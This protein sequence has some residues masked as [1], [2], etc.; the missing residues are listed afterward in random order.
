MYELPIGKGHQFLNS[1][2]A[3]HGLG[4]WKV[5]GVLTLM[6]GS[7]VNFS[8]SAAGLSAPGN[9]QSP[10][11][12]API[13]VLHG[14]NVGNPWFSTGSFAA[15]ATGVFGNVGRNNFSGPGFFNLDFSLFKIFK[16]SERMGLELRAES[17][18]VTNTPQFNNP[19]TTLGNA[20]FGF[21]TGAGGGRNMQ[22]GAKLTF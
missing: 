19:N 17:F 20:N 4:G 22:M 18:G 21:I 9:A 13:E 12:I 5:N 3:A 15:P 2:W 6:S 7:P 8:Y 11:Q 16:I 10:N 1:G 14:I